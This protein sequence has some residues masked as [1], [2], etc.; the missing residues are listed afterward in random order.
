M[1]RRRLLYML[2]LLIAF[3]S[4]VAIFDIIVYASAEKALYQDIDR[5]FAEAAKEINTDVSGA[6]DNF[7]DG[8]N[9]VYTGGGSYIIPYKI[10]LL[11]RNENGY[12]LNASRLTS[13]DYMLNI[14][15][16][17]SDKGRYKT[18]AAVRNGTTLSY[19]TYTMQVRVSTGTVYYIQMAT[20]STDIETSLNVILS[21]LERCTIAA[22]ALVLVVGWYLS[23]SLTKGV[24]EAWEKQ[25]EF[26]SYASHEIRSPLTVIHNSLELL[27]RNPRGVIIDHSDLI[28]NSLT[29]TN[30]LRK[31]SANLLEMAQL[32]ASDIVLKLEKI[33]LDELIASFIDP[34]QCQAELAEKKLDVR[35]GCPKP[36]SADKELIIELSVILLEN[37]IKYTDPGDSI[38]ISTNDNN[39]KAILK[40]TDTGI[41]I[42]DNAMEKVFT[43][44]YRDERQQSKKDGSGLGLYIANLIVTRHGGK[45]YAE[46]NYP[47]GTIFTVI[48]PQKNQ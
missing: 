38:E 21:V 23:K 39:S 5:Q 33:N 9:I 19:R 2:I 36:F 32:Q 46:H 34:F 4:I 13:F 12:I 41:G 47:K 14:G 44:F 15:F 30:R 35:L 16:S 7:L 45:I 8:N 22:L 31:M 6:I 43:R 28:M 1:L 40:V 24:T 27:L 37:A 3:L 48:L 25:D 11:L 17:V 29:E 42:S 26:I 10:F 18:E 20:N